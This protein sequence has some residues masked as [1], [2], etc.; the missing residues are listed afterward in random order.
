M[1][2]PRRAR[3]VF[4]GLPHHAGRLV[5]VSGVLP[6]PADK[7]R[8]WEQ[9]AALAVDMESSHV[10]EWATRAGLPAVAVRVV[11]D[12]PGEILP[13]S[14]AAALDPAGRLQA[15]RVLAWAGRPDQLRHAWRL[16]RCS[17]LALDRLARFLSAFARAPR[18]P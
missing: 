12:G 3:V 16:W 17:T 7:A 4:P 5:T 13:P 2:V 15:R 14:V 9:E 6:T 18:E 11:A 1:Y 10:L 8:C